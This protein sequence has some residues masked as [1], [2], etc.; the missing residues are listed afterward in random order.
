MRSK[1][2]GRPT[3]IWLQI[4]SQIPLFL[5]T[6]KLFRG[7][8]GHFA[9]NTLAWAWKKVKVLPRMEND[10][11]WRHRICSKHGRRIE[12]TNNDHEGVSEIRLKHC[13]KSNQTKTVFIC[14]KRSIL[15]KC[16]T[17]NRFLRTI[18]KKQCS[19]SHALLLKLRRHIGL[20]QNLRHPAF[21]TGC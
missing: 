3:Q 13:S 18:I 9:C 7:W 8:Y 17:Q 19:S 16:W 4:T 2:N 20:N 14:G 1:T 15:R 11:L 12:R 6:A 21:P 5:E 10:I